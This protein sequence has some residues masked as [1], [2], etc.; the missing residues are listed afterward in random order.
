MCD[1]MYIVN[2]RIWACLISV[3]FGWNKNVI[4]FRHWFYIPSAEIML[5]ENK[6]KKI[7]KNGV[8][9]DVTPCGSCKNRR[10]GG[11]WRLLHQGD[12][13]RGVTSQKTPFLIVTAVKTSNLTKKILIEFKIY[14]C[15]SS[16][17]LQ[18][19]FLVLKAPWKFTFIYNLDSCCAWPGSN[20]LQAHMVQMYWIIVLSVW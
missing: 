2:M 13:N 6:T 8:F 10:L 3:S 11:T 18:L 9:W 5:K 15:I 12:K 20:A 17:S 14:T 1:L 4:L 19:V 7:L 16:V